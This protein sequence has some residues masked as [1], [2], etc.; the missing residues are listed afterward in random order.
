MKSCTPV[1]GPTGVQADSE[2]ERSPPC[3]NRSAAPAIRCAQ[4]SE[5][6]SGTDCGGVIRGHLFRAVG[7]VLVV[8]VECDRPR[9]LLRAGVERHRASQ[10]PD[11]A[12]DRSGY[13]SD[14]PVRRQT[15]R[16]TS[17]VAVFDDGLMAV[18]IEND[19]DCSGLVWCGQWERLPPSCCEPERGVLE[20]RLRR[21]QAC[22]ELSEHLDVGVEGVAGC[23]PLLVGKSGPASRR[24]CYPL[25]M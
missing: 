20:L 7:V 14:G 24:H 9:D 1:G 5:N 11:A 12:E 2:I 22:G 15:H 4:F 3:V 13:L 8:L 19:D 23:A 21:G 6:G 25:R 10:T 17:I 18:N 16:A